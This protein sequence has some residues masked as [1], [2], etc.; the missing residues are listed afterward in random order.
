MRGKQT[1]S[2][3]TESLRE[4]PFARGAT[5]TQRR[6]TL[7]PDNATDEVPDDDLIRT[8]PNPRENRLLTHSPTTTQA[9]PAWTAVGGRGYRI[10]IAPRG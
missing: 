3:K 4:C 8:Q 5:K 9:Y 10:R 1:C 7:Q 6:D 2:L